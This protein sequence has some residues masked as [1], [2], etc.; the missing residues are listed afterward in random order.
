MHGYFIG[1][2]SLFLGLFA[3][4][5]H[6]NTECNDK[7]LNVETAV[8]TTHQLPLKSVVRIASPLKSVRKYPYS[9]YYGHGSGVLINIRGESGFILSASHVT[10]GHPLVLVSISSSSDEQRIFWAQFVKQDRNVDLALYKIIDAKEVHSGVE[11]F[12]GDNEIYQQTLFTVGY[13]SKLNSLSKA[14]LFPDSKLIIRQQNL[15]GLS[16]YPGVGMTIKPLIMSD[17]IETGLSGGPVFD[18][19]GHLFGINHSTDKRR[20]SKNSPVNG[21]II[22][23]LHILKFLEHLTRPVP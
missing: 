4:L 18:N 6:A 9:P 20:H 22:S 15:V 12:S 13:P 8:I 21:Y 10:A 16:K 11:I 17:C 2:L 14:E 19:E 23:S 5:T 1:I 3:P 7:S